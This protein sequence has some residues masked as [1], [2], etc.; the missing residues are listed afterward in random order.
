[1]HPFLAFFLCSQN[2]ATINAELVFFFSLRAFHFNTFTAHELGRWMLM[3]IINRTGK[4]R[5]ESFQKTSREYFL[6]FHQSLPIFVTYNYI[7]HNLIS[8]MNVSI[9]YIY[10][11]PLLFFGYCSAFLII[12][13]SSSLAFICLSGSKKRGRKFRSPVAPIHD[14]NTYEIPCVDCTVDATI[15]VEYTRGKHSYCT[16]VN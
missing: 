13:T 8:A 4:C 7:W 15:F 5:V 11:P 3:K 9:I 10:F 2:G 12:F 6:D 16:C 14:K 1:M